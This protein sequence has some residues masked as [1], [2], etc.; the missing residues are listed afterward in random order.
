[1]RILMSLPPSSFSSLYMNYIN[2]KAKEVVDLI[3]QSR[4]RI[5]SNYSSQANIAT[6]MA[7]SY[8]TLGESQATVVAQEGDAALAAQNETQ[9]IAGAWGVKP[10][11]DS[12]ILF[13]LGQQFQQAEAKRAMHQAQ[14]EEKQSVGLIENPLQYLINQFTV[15]QDIANYNV[16]DEDAKH[17]MAAMQQVNTGMQETA[18]TEAA[19]S[20]KVS[21]GANAAKVQIARTQA[22]VAAGEASLKAIQYGTDRLN[23]EMNMTTAQANMIYSDQAAQREAERLR[24]AH[25]ELALHK[26]DRAEKKQ[27]EDMSFEYYLD[28]VNKGRALRGLSPMDTKGLD[29]KNLRM[30][31]LTK[32]PIG[33]EFQVDFENGDKPAPILASTPFEAHQIDVHLGVNWTADQASIKAVFQ[34]AQQNVDAILRSGQYDSLDEKGVVVRKPIDRADK[35]LPQALFNQQ[36]A[37]LVAEDQKDATRSSSDRE[38]MFAVPSVGMILKTSKLVAENPV[39]K[40]VITPQ[41]VAGNNLSVSDSIK[42]INAAVGN[43]AVKF[44][45]A[46]VAMSYLVQQGQSMNLASKNLERFGIVAPSA[47]RTYNFPYKGQTYDITKPDNLR[48]LSL[49]MAWDTE[50]EQDFTSRASMLPGYGTPS[51]YNRAQ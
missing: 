40:Q 45:D 21:I 32:S 44:D 4:P 38:N 15:N 20:S 17:A 46:M 12:D 24:I 29:V 42:Q 31:I 27:M 14:I 5:D 34:K 19:I 1:M 33:K 37:A 2:P 43:G 3:Q 9:R 50:R 11:S 51:I 16:A 39:I 22:D 28:R 25:E 47:G 26:K 23:A 7:D 41:V 18:K 13:K 49:R 48:R 35:T 8:A 10:G 6:G 30:L 36:V